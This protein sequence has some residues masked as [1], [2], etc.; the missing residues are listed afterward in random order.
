MSTESNT[1]GIP[2]DVI[3]DAQLIADSV[4]AGKPIPPD[5]FRRVQERAEGIRQRVFQQ[6]GVV[7]VGV[8]AIRELRDDLAILV[9]RRTG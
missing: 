5:V 9:I 7:N 8:P 2:P 4:A 1:A 6:H 3:T